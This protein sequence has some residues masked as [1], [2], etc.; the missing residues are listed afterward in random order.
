MRRA[1]CIPVAIEL[2]L[3]CEQWRSSTCPHREVVVDDPHAGRSRPSSSYNVSTCR[4]WPLWMAFVLQEP[5]VHG[6]MV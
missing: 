6:V 5:E 4:T 2:K 1:I 3:S